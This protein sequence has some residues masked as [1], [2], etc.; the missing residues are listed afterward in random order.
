M[1]YPH[2]FAPITIGNAELRNRIVQTGHAT[3]YA[4]D[5]LPGARLRAYYRERARGGVAMIV[6]EVSAVHATGR[7]PN[8]VPH[9]FDERIVAAYREVTEELHALD[10]R[11]VAQLWHCGSNTDGLTTELPVWAPSANAGILHHELAHELTTAEIRELVAAYAT[12]A[13]HAVRGGTDGVEIHAAHG[14]LPMQFLSRF[15]NRRT[16][17][18]GGSLENRSRFLMEVLAAVREATGADP[19]VGVRLSAEEGV[20]LGLD[21]DESAEVARSLVAGGAVSY[22][23]VSFGNYSN[24]ELQI[25]PM[26][27]R[28]GH[29]SHLAAAVRK[30]AEGVPVLAVGRITTPEVAERILANGEADLVGMARQLMADPEFGVKAQSG[31]AAEIRRCVGANYCHSRVQTAR[32]LGC[33]Y[34]AATGRELELGLERLERADDPRRVAVVGGGPAGLEAARLAATRGHEVTVLERGT[35]LGGQLRLAA[36][37]A[38]RREMGLIADF[39]E[40][41]VRRLGADVRTGTEATVELLD[42]LA[43]DAVVIATGSIARPL[44]FSSA[45][46]DRPAI[47]GIETAR[48]LTGREVL[49]GSGDLDGR[50]LVY[51]IEG[52]VQGLS[53]AEH[54]LDQ[55][56]VVEL[57]TPHAFA[58]A[59]VGASAWSRQLA[60]FTLKGGTVTPNVLVDEVDGT[61][62]QLVD[63][64]AGVRS[65]REGVGAIVIVGDT[66]VDDGLARALRARGG[67]EPAMAGD[68]LAPRLLDIAI[69]EG[70]RAGRA[71]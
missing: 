58:G 57:V 44:G 20:P 33:I 66:V 39:L 18:Y 54:L 2:L 61:T 35:E 60:D 41:E 7:H 14:Y 15:T 24:M 30:V 6:S 59:R 55:G 38:S 9:L 31:R 17:A 3:G 53:V 36:R 1:P 42:G 47:P 64:Y 4:E 52:H 48:A 13:E 65:A 68:C 46:S 21:L 51:D 70:H 69:L 40:H 26:G 63:V 27:T 19:I 28:L 11:F 37:V 22:L 10:C 25:G 62:V 32:P 29:L 56:A 12:G 5:H 45:R 34:N 23:S 49:D 43:P 8:Q 16:D 50:V 67:P 71:L